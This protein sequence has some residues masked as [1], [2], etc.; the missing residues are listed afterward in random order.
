ME[1]E[2][3]EIIKIKQWINNRFNKTS[4]EDTNHHNQ[5]QSD[6]DERKITHQNQPFQQP[7]I[8]SKKPLW[9]NHKK[10]SVGTFDENGIFY[11]SDSSDVYS[12]P[13]SYD[14][15]SN[16]LL[17]KEKIIPPLP[18]NKNGIAIAPWHE[19][20]S[21]L[22]IPPSPQKVTVDIDEGVWYYIDTF[23]QLQGPFSVSDM[24][25]WY[26][27]GYFQN[28]LMIRRKDD[29]DYIQLTELIRYTGDS[30]YPFLTDFNN[31]SSNQVKIP[32]H[33]DQSSP[34][35]I[36]TNTQSYTDSK[37]TPSQPE[38]SLMPLE[39][40][41][42]YSF[43]ADSFDS[44][45]YWPEPPVSW[46]Q[47]LDETAPISC[48][49]TPT[50]SFQTHQTIVHSMDKSS[51]AYHDENIL[52]DNLLKQQLPMV[53]QPATSQEN[54][55][56]NQEAI[57]VEKKN[58][59]NK[60]SVNEK[61]MS[62]SSN[63]H[64]LE[65]PLALNIDIQTDSTTPLPE[66]SVENIKSLIDVPLPSS[67]SPM[68]DY[69]SVER[70]GLDEEFPVL[71]PNPSLSLI[72]EASVS[73]KKLIISNQTKK[74]LPLPVKE[75]K[76]PEKQVQ[77]EKKI[78]VTESPEAKSKDAESNSLTSVELKKKITLRSSIQT[79]VSL[80]KKSVSTPKKSFCDLQQEEKELEV[81][82][83]KELAKEKRERDLY[84]SV[85]LSCNTVENIN[86]KTMGSE[87]VNSITVR[88][89]PRPAID[90]QYSLPKV[91][92]MDVIPNKSA[93]SSMQSSEISIKNTSK[94]F[95]EWC[96]KSLRGL[97]PDVDKKEILNMLLSLSPEPISSDI[98]QDI[99]YANSVVLDGRRFAECFMKFREYDLASRLGDI[100][101][102]DDTE[103]PSFKVVTKKGKKKQH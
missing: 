6:Y 28:D 36:F 42:L 18:T 7:K 88:T 33:N 4:R 29:K 11:L 43:R 73:N 27:C 85:E 44:I 63:S 35:S 80:M 90:K 70:H 59:P 34:Y 40:S 100:Q 81:S 24:H 53:Y 93:T 78:A 12:D 97:K 38:T 52:L 3:E 65:I 77:Q 48:Y 69:L 46:L 67:S 87:S 86:I 49:G 8:Y 23:H 19:D 54:F 30:V 95:Y 57:Q 2:E 31:I 64:T 16:D 66:T 62:S 13:S 83:R 71:I 101:I 47:P 20:T 17:I 96:E 41:S 26:M 51:T 5:I 15:Y 21:S 32:S 56:V 60:E 103:S 14:S 50:P 74:T 82:K 102:I 68:A 61:H 39:N 1:P 55:P 37:L 92:N 25:A 9:Y 10:A 84:Q 89:D 91:W 98:I 72:L 45:P 76:E 99:I 94:L 79:N 22:E 75:N 58:E